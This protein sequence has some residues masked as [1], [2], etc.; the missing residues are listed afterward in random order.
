[1]ALALF[2]GV[3]PEAEGDNLDWS[4]FDLDRARLR[5]EG[6]WTKVR[7][8]RIVDLNLSAPALARMVEG[9]K[10]RWLPA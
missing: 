3:R 6:E 5:V 8:H 4:A 9:C 10:G 7:T 1:M 2:A